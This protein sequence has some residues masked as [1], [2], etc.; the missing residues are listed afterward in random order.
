MYF[1]SDVVSPLFIW[2]LSDSEFITSE[3]ASVG[4]VD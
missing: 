1:C 4:F 3:C 2:V